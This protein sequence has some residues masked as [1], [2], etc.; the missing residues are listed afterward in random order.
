MPGP[1]EELVALSG[2]MIDEEPGIPDEAKGQVKELVMEGLSAMDEAFKPFI[3]LF[4]ARLANLETTQKAQS[5]LV[6]QLSKKMEAFAFGVRL[7]IRLKHF[8]LI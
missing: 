2:K 6:I 5:D 3:E 7:E 8:P 4:N 1:D